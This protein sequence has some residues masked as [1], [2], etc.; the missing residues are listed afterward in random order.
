MTSNDVTTKRNKSPGS[1][2]T[3]STNVKDSKNSIKSNSNNRVPFI[4][5]CNTPVS[6][7]SNPH[8]NSEERTFRS[9]NLGRKGSND[10][11]KSTSSKQEKFNKNDFVSRYLVSKDNGNY[12]KYYIEKLMKSYNPLKKQQ[13]LKNNLKSK[14]EVKNNLVFPNKER[15]LSILDIP[16]DIPIENNNQLKGRKL[17]YYILANSE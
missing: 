11:N 16:S 4:K 17:S 2:N 12:S 14:C 3:A 6:K 7:I 8:N 15:K 1:F 5:K 13:E 9:M 10:M